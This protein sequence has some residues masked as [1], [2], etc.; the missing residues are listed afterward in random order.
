M[1]DFNAE[2]QENAINEFFENYCMKCLVTG[3]TC[4]KNPQKPSTIDLILTNRENSFCHT[5]I[6]ETGHYSSEGIF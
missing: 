4:Y 3:P 5:T 1:G 6:L 2:I